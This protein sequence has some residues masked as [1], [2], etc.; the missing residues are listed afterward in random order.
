MSTPSSN[1]PQRDFTDRDMQLKPILKFSVGILLF[2]VAVFA[3]VA[4]VQVYW[5]KQA[6]AADAQLPA[7]STQR[8]LP[9]Q[10]V[11]QVTEAKDLQA[12]R[13]WESNLTTNYAVVD[14]AA[15]VYRIPVD[16]AI[17]ILA[18]RGLPARSS[19]NP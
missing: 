19:S 13:A 9:S 1:G 17:E 12:H 16:R 10:A 5:E 6:A 3:A 8:Q 15:G 11:L 4:Y 7:M 2:T 18:A 14:Q